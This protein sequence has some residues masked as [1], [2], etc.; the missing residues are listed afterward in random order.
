MTQHKVM[1]ETMSATQEGRQ[2][3]LEHIAAHSA[4]PLPEVFN[5][6]A[7]VAANAPAS[8]KPAARGFWETIKVILKARG[9]AALKDIVNAFVDFLE[10][11]IASLDD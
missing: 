2:A 9:I 3:M 10:D 8:L 11:Y 6:A 4:A 5:F 1:L 7:K